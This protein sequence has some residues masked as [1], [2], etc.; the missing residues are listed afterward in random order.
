MTLTWITGASS[1]IGRA[2]AL[3]LAR[4]GAPVVASARNAEAL[5]ALEREGAGRIVA[6]PLDVTDHA[7][8]AAAVAAIEGAHGP[9]ARAILNAGTHVPMS[10]DDF[11]AAT[12][13]ALIDINL[14]GAANALEALLPR[15]AARRAGHIAVVASLAG[16]RGLPTAAA[17]G[18][19]KA[20]VINLCEALKP[21]CDRLG[22][23]LQL[24]D[25]GFVDTPLTRRNDFAMPF[26][27]PVEA[28][29]EAL[30][31]GLASRRFEI[32]FPRRFAAIMKLMR[33]L[34]YR[35][36]FAAVRRTTGK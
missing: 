10:A 20:A 15:M 18:A 1:G 28:A 22:I 2:L 34:P 19:S 8:V 21:D 6:W 33:I 23:K 25:P 24:V 29:S 26:L 13:R 36:Y 17:Y 11:S 16:Y 35:L 14:M 9:I 12:V 27:M 30:A 4:E 31:R 3:R 32:V 5:A 7:A